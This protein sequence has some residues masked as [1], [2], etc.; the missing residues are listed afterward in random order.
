MNRRGVLRLFGSGVVAWPC[1]TRLPFTADHDGVPFPAGGGADVLVRIL[2]RYMAENLRQTIVVQNLPGAGGASRS[3]R[4]R[5]GRWLYAG[6]DV[7]R[8]CRDG[9]HSVQSRLQSGARFR[10]RLQCRGKSIRSRGQSSG[11]GRQREGADGSC[12]R[13]PGHVE[14]RPQWRG[15]VDQSCDRAIEA[16]DWD[17]GHAGRLSRRQFLRQRRHCRPC[18]GDVLE[19]PGGVASR[20]GRPASC[21]R[22]HLAKRS[23]AAPICLR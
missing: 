4:S 9:S 16:K 11:A 18:A 5:A 8:L 21:P 17:L 14:F 6:V 10:P 3:G 2:T 12:T 13:S 23:S 7:G 1:R 15:D 22:G 20:C 19:Q